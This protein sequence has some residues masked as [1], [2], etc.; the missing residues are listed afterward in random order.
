MCINSFEVV[1]NIII[2][3]QDGSESEIDLEWA[4]IFYSGLQYNYYTY[5]C[6]FLFI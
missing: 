2:N 4:I 5:Y 1:K 6:K 3:L